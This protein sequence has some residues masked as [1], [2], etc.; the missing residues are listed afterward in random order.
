MMPRVYM[1]YRCVFFP[2]LSVHVY[3]EYCPSSQPQTLINAVFLYLT[4][5]TYAKRF[6]KICEANI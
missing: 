6:L 1:G 3:H 2:F 4:N 5:L